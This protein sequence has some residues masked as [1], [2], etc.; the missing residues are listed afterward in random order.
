MSTNV[1]NGI[2]IPNMYAPAL[3]EQ[4]FIQRSE[5]LGHGK[6]FNGEHVD[7]LLYR[8][9]PSYLLLKSYIV[10]MTSR[11]GKLPFLH[12]ISIDLEPR[13]IRVG[14]SHNTIRQHL[15]DFVSFGLLVRLSPRKHT[16][17]INPNM[18][19]YLTV[20]QRNEWPEHAHL[21]PMINVMRMPGPEID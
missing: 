8:S 11:N 14:L 4:D 9:N 6:H 7:K 16:Y 19:H 20:A 21:F 10:V 12:A 18:S 17:Y 5:Y 2:E 1:Q 3:A 15:A 13:S